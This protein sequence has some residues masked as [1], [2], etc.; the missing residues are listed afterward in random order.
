MYYPGMQGGEAIAQVLLGEVNPSGKLPVTYP[1][2]LEDN[3]AYVNYPGGR[4]LYYGERLYVGYRYYQ[5]KGVQPLFPFGHG[6]SY[7]QFDY[8]RLRVPDRAKI[9]D[10]VR[11]AVQ[12]ANLGELDGKE[13]VQVYVHDAASSLDR[14]QSE[15]K[16]FQKVALKA[17]ESTKL[18]FTLDERAFA[19]YDPLQEKW[20]VEPGEFQIRVGSSSED[21]RCSA[22]IILD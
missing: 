7:T 19:F 9:G 21:I 12:V 3:P 20:V 4:K 10:M 1:H 18:E 14:P 6:L 17:G 8:K 5:T 15:L 22:K 11:F 2:R 13:T 16:A